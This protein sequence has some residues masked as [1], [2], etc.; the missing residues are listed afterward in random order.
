MCSST[1]LPFSLARECP[2]NQRT[3]VASHDCKI[4][5]HLD[6]LIMSVALPGSCPTHSM[7]DDSEV[8]EEEEDEDE[9]SDREEG[10][11]A[12]ASS[13]HA[14]NGNGHVTSDILMEQGLACTCAVCS[15]LHAFF[16]SLGSRT[17]SCSEQAHCT[18]ARA[19]HTDA[20]EAGG[21]KSAQK[22]R[23][24]TPYMTK[25]ERARILG[26]RALQ[27][28]MNAPVQVGGPR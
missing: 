2:R 22:Q 28:S 24:T 1:D 13:S 16:I 7:E 10:G 19:H 21:E 4:P 27:I 9:D 14:V 20:A 5:C 11:A 8:D 25:Y 3:L 26:A 6:A 18:D 17:Y 23:S 12:K 15:W